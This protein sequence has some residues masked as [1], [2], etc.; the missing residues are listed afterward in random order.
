M[1]LFVA[2]ISKEKKEAE[3]KALFS[4][5]GTV[6]EIKMIIDAETQAFRGFAFVTMSSEGQ[7]NKAIKALHDTTL[8]GQKLKVEKAQ[9]QNK[10]KKKKPKPIEESKSSNDQ[11]KED[12][13]NFKVSFDLG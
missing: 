4:P 13:S 1:K 11:N 3:L 5:Y 10:P 7:G 12:K 8:G 6:S 2:N 9:N